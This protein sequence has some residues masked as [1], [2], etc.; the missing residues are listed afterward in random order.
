VPDITI[1]ANFHTYEISAIT[2]YL[3]HPEYRAARAFIAPELKLDLKA[4]SSDRSYRMAAPHSGHMVGKYKLGKKLGEGAFGLVFIAHDTSLD[5]DVALKFLHSHHISNPQ[6]FERFLQEARTVAKLSHPGIVTVHELGTADDGIAY[7]AMELLQ[8]ESLTDR[9]NRVGR[10]SP[11]ESKE[12]CLQIA[13]T[14]NVAHVAGIV[15]RDLK[16]DNLFLIADPTMPGRERVKVLDFGIAKLAH[17]AMSSV[18][19]GSLLIGTP[20]YMSPEQC[21]S[22]AHIDYRSD[23]YALGCILYELV[24]GRPAFEGAPGELLIK[25][26]LAPVLPAREI[27]PDLPHE[28]DW[29]ISRMLAKDPAERPQTMEHVQ[30]ELIGERASGASGANMAS[31]ASMA[32]IPRPGTVEPSSI[33]PIPWSSQSRTT[34]SDS[35]GSS[36]TPARTRRTNAVVT[37]SI[38]LAVV[39]AGIVIVIRTLDLPR[40][41][42]PIAAAPV[43]FAAPH[44]QEPVTTDAEARSSAPVSTDA[45]VTAP[46]ESEP[47]INARHLTRDNITAAV[48]SEYALE[49][50]RCYERYAK[51]NPNAS[52]VLTVTLHVALTGRVAEYETNPPMKECEVFANMRFSSDTETDD[53][54]RRIRVE[55]PFDYPSPPVRPSVVK[56]ARTSHNCPAGTTW[57]P[58]A[59]ACVA[60]PPEKRKQCTPIKN[61]VVDPFEENPC[62]P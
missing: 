4:M 24:C 5:R 36:R 26:Q 27:V 47:S 59:S 33:T 6:A 32:S 7:I 45:S 37:S 28:L 43:A 22:S 56:P 38:L 19:T 41:A 31:M 11:N 54:T 20:R 61:G 12:I 34:L 3:C 44:V 49:I 10:L 1:D 14:L 13:S 17:T 23:I 29:L 46:E 30:S 35:T 53:P 16:P 21:R 39:I 52:R 57:Q 60:A 55:I 2:T 62:R 9:L 50:R 8:G 40:A 25:H 18:Q 15:H 58:S 51:N 42:P 48:R